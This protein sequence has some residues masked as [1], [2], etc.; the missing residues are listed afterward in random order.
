VQT[1]KGGGATPPL[2]NPHDGR[3]RSPAPTEQSEWHDATAPVVGQEAPVTGVREDT[4]RVNLTQKFAYALDGKQKRVEE[5]RD[6]GYN[7][8]EF[9]RTRSGQGYG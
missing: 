2:R 4:F 3:E 7:L 5:M 8:D 1:K 6:G 9:N